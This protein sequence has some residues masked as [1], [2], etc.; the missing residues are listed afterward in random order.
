MHGDRNRDGGPDEVE[1][2]TPMIALLDSRLLL[3]ESTS[4]GSAELRAGGT[5][6]AALTRVLNS[7]KPR[8]YKGN[9]TSSAAGT[10]KR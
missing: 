9:A 6:L 7:K 5:R 1:S 10:I 4:H 3:P 2:G 8:S